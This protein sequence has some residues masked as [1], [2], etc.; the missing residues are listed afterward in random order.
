M[1]R[2]RVCA[3]VDHKER[4]RRDLGFYTFLHF[5]YSVP[6][7]MSVIHSSG[8]IMNKRIVVLLATAAAFA[9]GAVPATASKSEPGTIETANCS[10]QTTAFIAQIG[11]EG[12]I[13]GVA[14]VADAFGFT[15]QEIHA[16]IDN[17]CAS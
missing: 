16:L 9:I 2:E 5:R 7:V 4:D 13:H 15:V 1:L 14:G 11:A 17:Y 3:P 12:G 6:L 10:G 8:D